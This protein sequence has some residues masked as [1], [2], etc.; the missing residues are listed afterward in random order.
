MKSIDTI[1]TLRRVAKKLSFGGRVLI[2]QRILRRLFVGK[3]GI[4]HIDDFDGDL[5]IDLRLS[6]HMQSRIFWVEYYSSDIVTLLNR[7]LRPGMVIIDIGVNIGEITLVAAKRTGP[8]GQVIAFEPVEKIAQVLEENVRRNEL[9]WVKVIRAGVSASEGR[10]DIY[11]SCGQGDSDDEHH[12]LSRIYPSS[13]KTLALQSI[14]LTTLDR[15][16]SATPVDHL[17]LIKIDIEGAEL[18]CLQGAKH[19]IVRYKPMLIV[20]IQAV[21]ASVA[22]Y[23]QTDILNYLAQFGYSFFKI[24]RSG[25]LIE[26]NSETLSDFQNVLCVNQS[27][28]DSSLSVMP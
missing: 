22:G 16:I 18:P 15:F 12:G 28:H 25:R 24:E 26:L 17:D 2:A 13:S 5:S 9:D 23:A 1:L 10:A 20:E 7:I 3:T 27:A 6:E 19:T 8:T 4:A 21:T 14:R 11:F